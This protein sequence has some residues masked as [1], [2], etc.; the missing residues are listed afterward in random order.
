MNKTPICLQGTQ[1]LVEMGEDRYGTK[2]Y[3]I[4]IIDVCTKSSEEEK[5]TS[6]CSGKKRKAL[7]RR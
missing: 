3:N 2:Y 5:E 4:S 1:C 6:Y 7:Q